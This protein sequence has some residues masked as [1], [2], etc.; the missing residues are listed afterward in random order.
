MVSPVEFWTTAKEFARNGMQISECCEALGLHMNS[1]RIMWT[2]VRREG[3][4]TMTQIE[5]VQYRF[6]RNRR[7]KADRRYHA[8]QIGKPPKP[9]PIK[10]E[11]PPSPDDLWRAAM[12]GKRFESFKIQP[13]TP[14]LFNAVTP[15]AK[16]GG[17]SVLGTIATGE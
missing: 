13:Q 11:P 7:N 4:A 1:A 16:V 10:A 15:P 17:G 3:V 9:K 5:D 2:R 12:E 14:T 8:A 6:Y